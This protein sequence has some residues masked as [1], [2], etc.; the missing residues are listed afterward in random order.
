MV[1][2][3]EWWQQ[4]QKQRQWWGGFLRTQDKDHKVMIVID[5]VGI[6]YV[7]TFTGVP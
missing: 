1:L 5:V 2:I 4:W 6:V 3:E 7:K